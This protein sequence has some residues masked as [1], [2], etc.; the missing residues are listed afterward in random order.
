MAKRHFT[1]VFI[2]R[3]KC[4]SLSFMENTLK[5]EK[6]LEWLVLSGADETIGDMPVNRFALPAKTAKAEASKQTQSFASPSDKNNV[7]SEDMQSAA[8]VQS[9]SSLEELKEMIA[10]IECPL[11]AN[12]THLVFG[13]GNPHAELMIV[14]EAP[15]MEED[16][17]GLPFV[18]ASGKLLESM[19][20][21]IGLSRSEVYITNILPWRPLGNRKPSEEETALFTPFVRR[22]IFLIKPKILLMLGSCSVSALM[23]TN[24]GI[25]RIRG[26][27]MT[28]AQENLSLPAIASFHPAFLLRTPAQKKLAWRDFLSVKEQL[29]TS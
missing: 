8:M 15:G 5:T 20:G 22:H 18:G 28:Y 10:R 17:Q 27:W 21:S 29:K 6:T 23:G 9:V 19:L 1:D 2:V 3:R 7:F 24:E 16:R 26:R 11:K 25:T 4:G 12:A 14:G 13:S